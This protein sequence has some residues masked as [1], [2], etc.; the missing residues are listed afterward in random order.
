M[1][2][3][4]AALSALLL[5]SSSSLASN[6][7]LA[8]DANVIAANNGWSVEQKREANWHL[9]QHRRLGA[10]IAGLAP[11]RPGFVDVYVISIGLDA[12]PVFGR[13]ATEA[14][15]VL[16]RRYGGTGRTITLV[17]GAE[18]HQSPQGSPANLATAL[19]AVAAKMNVREDVLIVYA[20]SHGTA[21]VGL[22]YRDGEAGYGF[23]S[24]KRLASLLDGL[25]IRRRMLLVSAC[26]SGVFVPALSS[27]ATVIVTAASDMRT[28]FG[29]AA[30]ND[31]TYFGDAL[32]NTALRKTQPFDKAVSESLILINQW[33]SERGLTSSQPQIFVGASAK[34]WLSIIEKR[35]PSVATAKVGRP[36]TSD[37][38]AMAGR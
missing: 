21:D 33:E 30:A 25:G 26:F 11:Q 2:R 9:D 1:G 24:P 3:L 4:L 35:V 13:E 8:N 14:G 16:A 20:T 27:D 17:T 10:A 34:D 29:C 28:S 19:A 18:G 22:V 12:D 5:V 7:S 15:K 32:I 23:I 6:V 36:A 31:W 37:D 38:P